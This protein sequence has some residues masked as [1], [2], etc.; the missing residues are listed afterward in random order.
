MLADQHARQL[1]LR[2]CA[3]RSFTDDPDGYAEALLDAIASFPPARATA[4][5]PRASQVREATGCLGGL[6]LLGSDSLSGLEGAVASRQA[7]LD[8][9][10]TAIEEQKVRLSGLLYEQAQV[11]LGRVCLACSRAQAEI[12]QVRLLARTAQ[13]LVEEGPIHAFECSQYLGLILE[14]LQLKLALGRADLL[15]SVYTPQVAE[16]LARFLYAVLCPCAVACP[17]LG[18][19]CGTGMRSSGARSSGCA[20]TSRPSWTW[21]RRPWSSAPATSGCWTRSSWPATT[22]RASATRMCYKY[23]LPVAW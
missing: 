6:R 19:P 13:V 23:R 22:L 14:N 21:A 12:E 4:R 17:G 20:R 5:G 16:V 1:A 3:R 15:A 10:R 18:C 11:R 9:T 2:W 8:R 7:L